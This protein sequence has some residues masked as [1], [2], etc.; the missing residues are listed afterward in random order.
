MSLTKV[1]YS[2]IK[3]APANVLDFGAVGDGVTDDTTTF[4]VAISAA[5]ILGTKLY[6]PGGSYLLGTLG[7][8]TAPLTIYGDGTGTVLKFNTTGKCFNVNPATVAQQRNNFTFRDLKFI[9]ST[10]T[11]ESFI[12]NSN[13]LNVLVDRC[14]FTDSSVTYAVDQASGYGFT[15][16][17]CVFSDLTGTGLILRDNDAT[18]NYSFVTKI[19]RCDF[20]RCSIDAVESQ[21]TG[22][23]PVVFDTCVFEASGGLGYRGNTKAG[24]GF[25]WNVAFNGCYFEANAGYDISINPNGSAVQSY[26]VLTAC[27]FSGVPTIDLGN[28]GR[29]QINSCANSGG[30]I[31]TITGSANAEVYLSNCLNFAQSGTFLWS[32]DSGAT[33][34]YTP[35]ISNTPTSSVSGKYR[36]QGRTLKG[37]VSANVSGAVT[38][39]I[40]VSLPFAQ[41]GNVAQGTVGIATATKNGVGYYIGSVWID[42]TNNVLKIHSQVGGVEWSAAQPFV[43]ANLDSF[44]IEFEYFV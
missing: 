7:D 10:N 33:S 41:S 13:G 23:G 36:V 34:S 30:N 6:V 8:I 44:S 37:A 19:D 17:S 29:L 22:V 20:T 15:L 4:N 3:G 35:T 12:C 16:R 18:P 5:N 9:N 25:S 42:T 38:G 39:T 11:P 28:N 40:S 1:T 2:I 31:C 26:A 24:G 14:Y 32:D 43:W 21:G 27:Q